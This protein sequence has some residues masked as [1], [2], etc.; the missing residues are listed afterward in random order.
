MHSS[1]RGVPQQ[2]QVLLLS[3]TRRASRPCGRRREQSHFFRC[4][5]FSLLRRSGT[6]GSITPQ[7]ATQQGILEITSRS[8]KSQWHQHVL[9]A[10]SPPGQL[11]KGMI[12]TAA[13]VPISQHP[14]GQP[15]RVGE[16]GGGRRVGTQ[17][18]T[19]ATQPLPNTYMYPAAVQQR[20]RSAAAVGAPPAPLSQGHPARRKAVGVGPLLSICLV[21]SLLRRSGTDGSITSSSRVV[22]TPIQLQLSTRHLVARRK[23]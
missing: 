17:S 5:V 4:L 16:V 13:Q 8:S 15:V 11:P 9:L 19:T 14:P 1:S 7:T 23:A 3:S 12:E 21:F 22:A 20:W 2:Q 10:K 6:V 18:E